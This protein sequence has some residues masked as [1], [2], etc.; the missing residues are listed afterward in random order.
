MREGR[1]RALSA[2]GGYAYSYV[3]RRRYSV[4]GLLS[5]G[6]GPQEVAVH[7]SSESYT[8]TSAQLGSYEL[9]FGGGFNGETCFTGIG[10]LYHSAD[11]QTD[12]ARVH[13][14]MTT[15]NVF[16]GLRIDPGWVV[17]SAR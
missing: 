15:A 6:L 13:T 12:T 16:F 5:V 8:K 2:K 4:S 3:W 7:T 9:F 10:V 11:F 14:Q 17:G 1:L